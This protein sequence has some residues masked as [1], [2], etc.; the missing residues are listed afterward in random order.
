MGSYGTCLEAKAPF[1]AEAEEPLVAVED[2]YEASGPGFGYWGYGLGSG[3]A[4]VHQM[5]AYL[6]AGAE[7]HSCLPVEAG[8]GSG[9]SEAGGFARPGS[10]VAEAAGYGHCVDS[11]GAEPVDGFD[12]SEHEQAAVSVESPPPPEPHL[13]VALRV[14]PA[15]ADSGPVHLPIFHPAHQAFCASLGASLSNLF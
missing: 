14:S 4:V 6:D 9:G 11:A 2:P 13:L 3:L 5:E 10:E 12:D 15:A 8:L 7:E 1:V